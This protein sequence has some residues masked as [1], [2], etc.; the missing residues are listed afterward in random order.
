MRFLTL[1]AFLALI[2]STALAHDGT[3]AAAPL[4]SSTDKNK[5]C[6]YVNGVAPYCI[7]TDKVKITYVSEDGHKCTTS[8]QTIGANVETVCLK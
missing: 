8:I 1:A 6:I 3:P 5:V 4:I 2:S 7:P